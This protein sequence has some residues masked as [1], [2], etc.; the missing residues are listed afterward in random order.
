MTTELNVT[1]SE[2]VTF[3]SP[4]HLGCEFDLDEENPFKS[5]KKRQ[6]GETDSPIVKNCKCIGKGEIQSC[7]LPINRVSESQRLSVL[8]RSRSSKLGQK[9]S[10]KV[11]IM[12]LIELSGP[13][14]HKINKPQ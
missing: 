8:F 6:V 11:T 5:L 9:K 10:L 7:D 4:C 1:S 12:I 13:F 3:F 14:S 2:Q